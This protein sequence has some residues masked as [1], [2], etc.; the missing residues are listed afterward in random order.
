MTHISILIIEYVLLFLIILSITI[1]T[2][3]M[4]ADCIHK[5]FKTRKLMIEWFLVIIFI[6]ILGP[7]IYYFIVKRK[8]P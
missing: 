5:K 2:F 3:M 8:H 4:I 7:L 6:P 1:F